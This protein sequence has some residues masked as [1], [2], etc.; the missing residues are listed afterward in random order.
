MNSILKAFYSNLRKYP[1]KIL[2]LSPQ[3]LSEVD[4]LP[5]IFNKLTNLAFAHKVVCYNEFIN[6]RRLQDKNYIIIE[7]ANSINSF[8]FIFALWR[9][10]SIPILINPKFTEV[11]IEAVK[12]IAATQIIVTNKEMEGFISKNDSL[13]ENLL[14]EIENDIKLT[15]ND[16]QIAVVIA[17]S[18]TSGN[19]KLAKLSFK[20]LISSFNNAKDI[21]GYSSKDVWLLSLPSFHIGGFQII[22]RTI[23]SNGSAII[24]DGKET[25][26]N[27]E[28]IFI[29]SNEAIPNKLSLVSTQLKRIV[30]NSI[31]APYS[32]STI[33]AGGGPISSDI[34]SKVIELGWKIFKVYGSTETAAFITCLSKEDFHQKQESAGKPISNVIVK[35]F[36]NAGNEVRGGQYGEIAVKSDSIFEGYLNNIED[37]KSK[38]MNNHYLTGDIGYIDEDGYLYIVSRKDDIINTGG[39]KVVPKEVEERLREYWKIDDA[40]VFGLESKEWGSK[41]CAAIIAGKEDILLSEITDYLSKSLV[42]YKIPKEVFLF[43][44]FPKT[45]LGKIKKEDVKKECAVYNPT[46]NSDYIIKRLT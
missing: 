39:E 15:T 36:D 19:I 20:N 34:F 46:L 32:E 13:C 10:N 2:F 31:F 21:I 43:R 3:K 28:D 35:A 18:G 5:F 1:S 4:D 25:S 23:L 16:E 40:Y 37:T 42:K 8:A 41:V 11:E 45:E 29:Q 38:F 17:T 12:K 33:L 6:E 7:Q 30:D 22:M 26:R 27:F 9:N 14:T 44:V 24:Y